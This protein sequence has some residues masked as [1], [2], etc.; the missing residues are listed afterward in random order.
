MNFNKYITTYIHY[1]II[2]NSF[3]TLNTFCAI[4]FYP[5]FSPPKTWNPFISNLSI[6][7]F[8]K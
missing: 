6:S 8:L 1:S 3:T 2:P 5:S 4:L 7:L